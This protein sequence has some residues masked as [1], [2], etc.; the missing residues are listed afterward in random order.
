MS[1][2]FALPDCPCVDKSLTL[3]LPILPSRADGKQI[4]M[5]LVRT[6]PPPLQLSKRLKLYASY[7]NPN[8][9]PCD[10]GLVRRCPSEWRHRHRLVGPHGQGLHEGRG[11]SGRL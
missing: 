2:L 5:I 8:L 11:T 3:A 4:Q 9:A 10:L 6:P 7:L 1:F